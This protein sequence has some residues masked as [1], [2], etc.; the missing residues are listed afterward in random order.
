[1]VEFFLDIIYHLG[2]PNC[3]ITDNGTEFTGKKFL[4]FCDDYH[5]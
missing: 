2:F 3:I 1:L 5:I 4:R